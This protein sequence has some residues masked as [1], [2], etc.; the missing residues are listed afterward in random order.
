MVWRYAW[1]HRLSTLILGLLL[2][3]CLPRPG[4]AHTT[5][6]VASGLMSGFFHPVTG[7]DHV[8][9]MVA[10]GTWG[11]Q[12]GGRALWLLPITFLA[13]MIL[14][15]ALGV[16][17]LAMAGVEIGVAASALVL[18]LMIAVAAYAPLWGALAIICVAALLHGY[19]HALALP[20][21][22]A[23]MAFGIGFVAAT[24][25]LL[26][27]GIGLGM[28]SYWAVGRVVVRL[29]GVGIA[30]IGG[31]FLLTQTASMS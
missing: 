30:A 5:V 4:S 1:I 3:M 29:V 19:S 12:L 6:G 25:Y 9:A 27:G 24:G 31:W 28:L 7:L 26:L 13:I 15:A 20:A 23:P 8:A 10:V 16:P 21:A 22:A 14:G 17:N 2:L 11:V 18:G